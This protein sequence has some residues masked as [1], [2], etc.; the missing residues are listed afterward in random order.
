[1]N[2]SES[3]PIDFATSSIH[4][5][6]PIA[7]SVS[8]CCVK[9]LRVAIKVDGYHTAAVAPDECAHGRAPEQCRGVDAGQNVAVDRGPLEGPR[10]GVRNGRNLVVGTDV[11][12]MDNA[13]PAKERR[14]PLREPPRRARVSSAKSLAESTFCHTNP[15]RWLTTGQQ[16]TFEK[17]CTSAQLARGWGDCFGHMLVATGRADVMI[18]PAMNAWDAAALL[19]IIEEAGGHFLDWS[20]HA[21]IY[22]GNGLSVTPGLKD[23]VLKIVQS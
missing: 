15:A 11:D 7:R 13:E 17:L 22:S 19:P 4:S 5:F 1:M 3:Q 16:Q 2:F 20:G 18:D 21:S 12:P 23:E 14:L 10:D 6:K 8:A 9:S